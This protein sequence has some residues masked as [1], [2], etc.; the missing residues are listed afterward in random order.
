MSVLWVA[1]AIGVVLT[2]GGIIDPVIRR[3][4]WYWLAWGLS[5]V[6]AVVA[7]SAWPWRVVFALFAIRDGYQ[8]GKWAP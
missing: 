8:A 1:L 5:A 3:R 4:R 6:L 2:V 7:N